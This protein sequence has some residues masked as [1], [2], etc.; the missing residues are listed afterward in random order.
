MD[1]VHPLQAELPKLLLLNYLSKPTNATRVRRLASRTI[2]VLGILHMLFSFLIVG[3]TAWDC[4]YHWNFAGMEL[5]D[6]ILSVVVHEEPLPALALA[7]AIA[8]ILQLSFSRAIGRGQKA[9]SIV[10]CFSLIPSGIIISI[11]MFAFGCAGAWPFLGY[12]SHP[13]WWCL[14][15][16]LPMLVCA[17]LLLLVKDL[18]TMLLW[19][20]RHP[21]TEKPPVA[22]LP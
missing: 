4:A 15:L 21:N 16:I 8:G 14:L 9:G 18:N 6:A 13:N 19:I 17:V 2:L 3:I 20:V 5:A 10:C 7:T 12:Q 1:N 22:F 11:A